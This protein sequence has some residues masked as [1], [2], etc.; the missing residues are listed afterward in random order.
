MRAIDCG[1]AFKFYT[2]C[3]IETFEAE[4]P[5]TCRDTETSATP[6][7]SR[8]VPCITFEHCIRF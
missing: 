4:L 8:S 7:A 3:D 5:G 2:S 1:N 6:D